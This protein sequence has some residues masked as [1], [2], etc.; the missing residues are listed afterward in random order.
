[1]FVGGTGVF[2]GVFVGVRVFVGVGVRVLVAVGVG[3]RVNVGVLV[4]VLVGVGEI[5]GFP[6]LPVT[7]SVYGPAASA[8]AST[9]SCM[10]SMPK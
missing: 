1:V 5:N 9:V 3:V 7:W 4:G 8:G 2:V 6:K 10:E